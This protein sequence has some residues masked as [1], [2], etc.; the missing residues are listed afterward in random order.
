MNTDGLTNDSRSDLRTQA[1]DEYLL[2][3]MMDLGLQ[4]R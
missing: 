1:K 3:M 2:F 4:M